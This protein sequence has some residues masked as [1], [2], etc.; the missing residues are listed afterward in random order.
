MREGWALAGTFRLVFS[1]NRNKE[2]I[3]RNEHESLFWWTA[4]EARVLDQVVEDQNK[5]RRLATSRRA[6]LGERDGALSILLCSPGKS[7]HYLDRTDGWLHFISGMYNGVAVEPQKCVALFCG[8][9]T[10]FNC[11]G[12][13]LEAQ[14]WWAI[15]RV[16]AI[17][18]K[19]TNHTVF[20]SLTRKH[21]E[22]FPCGIEMQLSEVRALRRQLNSYRVGEF[23]SI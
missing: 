19:W 7:D 15:N 1:L 2:N 4:S 5:Q 6:N 3:H 17:W 21:V 23:I 8:L 13:E 12:L 18:Q 16:E 22:Y 20:P 9:V 11:A 10:E 14:Y